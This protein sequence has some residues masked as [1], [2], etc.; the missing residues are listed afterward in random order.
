MNR[1]V[2]AAIVATVV[3]VAVVV[4]GF[5]GLGSPRTQRLIQYDLRTVQSIAGLAQQIN[6]SWAKEAKVLPNDLEKFP[7]S[8]KQVPPG[9]PSLNYR[10]KSSNEYELCATFARDN[11]NDPGVNTGDPWIH[12]QG[13]YCFQFDASGPVPTVP[14]YY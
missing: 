11:R 7:S 14:Y 9:S 3:V 4:L 12:A 1:N 2:W 13:E 8:V 6:M 5:R 10:V